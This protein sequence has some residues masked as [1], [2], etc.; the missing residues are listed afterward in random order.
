[1]KDLLINFKKIEDPETFNITKKFIIS[2]NYYEMRLD[3]QE[4]LLNLMK[5]FASNELLKIDKLKN[6]K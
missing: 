4:D 1:M 2:S 5:D 6:K 3:E